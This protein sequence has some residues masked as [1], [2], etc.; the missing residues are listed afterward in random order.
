MKKALALTLLVTVL[1][2][3]PAA[4]A[5]PQSEIDVLSLMATV[6]QSSATDSES[7]TQT[8]YYD[9]SSDIFFVQTRLHDFDSDTAKLAYAVNGDLY[10]SLL[11][12]CKTLYDVLEKSFDDLGY[13]VDIAITCTASDGKYHMVYM[14]GVDCTSLMNQ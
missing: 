1:L 13:T 9:E 14:N 12:T 8:I 3:S 7:L 11:T 5:R 6:M 4:L 2:A 10:D